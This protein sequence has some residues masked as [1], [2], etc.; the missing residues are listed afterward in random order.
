MQLLYL[1]GQSRLFVQYRNGD[2]KGLHAYGIG[3]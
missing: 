2:V 3:Q 1:P